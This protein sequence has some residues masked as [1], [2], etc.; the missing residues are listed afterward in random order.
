MKKLLSLLLVAVM[1]FS[2]AA[3]TKKDEVKEPADNG[4]ETTEAVTEAAGLTGSIT[5]QAETTW[6]AYY[7]AAIDRVIAN[8]PD[9]KI[10]I[11]EVGSF[12]HL[13]TIDK[14]DVTNADVADVFALPADR[15]YG[16][17][18]KQALA[19]I[20]AEAMAANV[21]G[22]ADYNAGL[23]GNFKIDDSYLA[24]PMNIETLIAFVNTTNATAANIDTSKAME[25]TTLDPQSILIPAFDAWFGVALTNS[26]NI[27]FLGHDESG[28]LYSDLTADWKDL[29]AE[30]QAVF[31]ALFNYWNAHAKAGTSLWD[32]DA[33][34]GYM[35]TEFTSGGKTAVRIDGPWSTG[36]LSGFANNGADLGVLPI[37]EITFNGKPL[38]HWQGGWGLGVN[39]RCE[40]D[41][42]KMA[43]AQAVIEEIV[44]TEHAI[45]FFK[46]T[47]K[48]MVNV[49]PSVYASSDLSDADKT[50]ISAVVESYKD[51]PARP[52]FS[53]WGGVWDTWKNAMLSWSA[54][55]PATVEAAY[56]EVQASFKA[57]MLN[58]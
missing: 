34:W 26:A 49:D 3:C 55:K 1:V 47:G 16:L 9:A 23:G 5:V 22:F 18:E 39:A 43:L 8:N 51:A 27:E 21:G 46:A 40:G 20:D 28:N 31:T 2:L 52:L 6:V 53:E 4:S 50:V 54:V 19:S 58:F 45:D 56:A 33:A 41:A 15:I 7:Q 24:F 30:K 38:L 37:T 11:I 17:S 14:T 35:D 36:N 48:I 32:K 25:F 10:E 57:M 44:N 42:E 13:D 29:P 12:D